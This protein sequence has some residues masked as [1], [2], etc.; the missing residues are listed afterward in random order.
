MSITD[1][2]AIDCICP[3][4]AFF[5]F[6]FCCF[7]C[8]MRLRNPAADL[9]F[10]YS[11][12]AGSVLSICLVISCFVVILVSSTS[13]LRKQVRTMLRG[14]TSPCFISQC[15]GAQWVL[16]VE[17]SIDSSWVS[18]LLRCIGRVKLDEYY[19]DSPRTVSKFE[20]VFRKFNC[21]FIWN[22]LK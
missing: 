7:R 18:E 9:I 3:V 10:I 19:A 15:V 12:S 14:R 4:F 6:V 2:P 5:F 16:V 11:H 22:F 17:P 1:E 8:T 21:G 13:Y 20:M